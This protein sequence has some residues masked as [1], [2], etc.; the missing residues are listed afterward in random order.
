MSNLFLAVFLAV[1]LFSLLPLAL[2][3]P[4]KARITCKDGFQAT[5]DGGWISTPY[6][7]DEYLAEAGR[8][9]GMKVTGAQVRANPARKDEVCRLLAGT[10]VA[11]DYCPTDGSRSR[12][13]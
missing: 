1:S 9:R 8:K 13:R 3:V 4:A 2:S 11:M 10:P 7:N 12:G 5:K 6:C